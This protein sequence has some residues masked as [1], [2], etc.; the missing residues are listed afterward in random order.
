[1]A[2]RGIFLRLLHDPQPHSILTVSPRDIFAGDALRL[3]T[4]SR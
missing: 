2:G 4:S 3:A 1:V